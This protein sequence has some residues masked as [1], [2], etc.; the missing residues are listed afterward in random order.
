[1][2][3][4]GVIGTGSWGTALVKVLSDNGHSVLWFMHKPEIYEAFCKHRKSPEFFL[5]LS[6]EGKLVQPTLSKEQVCSAQY[7]LLACPSAYLPNYLKGL[8]VAHFE[9][10]TI[11]SAIKGFVG[12]G[13]QVVSD[14]LKEHFGVKESQFYVLSGPS[15]AEEVVEE[16]ITFVQLGGIE[17]SQRVLR[18]FQNDYFQVCFTA[19][20]QGLQLAGILKNVYAIALGIANGLGYGDNLQAAFVTACA[21]ETNNIFEHLGYGVTDFLQYGYLGDLLVTAYSMHSR[22]RRFGIGI[23]QGKDA[24]QAIDELHTTPEGYFTLQK[25][26]RWL[27]ISEF[28]ILHFVAQS[29]QNPKQANIALKNLLAHLQRSS[30]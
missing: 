27:N 30:R 18:L 20:Y 23:G 22:N 8:S 24:S 28:P 13:G 21:K 3:K 10:R 5:E 14:Y 4:I 1:M 15:H 29:I 26:Q 7:L 16:K 12:E 9:G 17:A 19:D 11:I 2:E 6:F 25:I